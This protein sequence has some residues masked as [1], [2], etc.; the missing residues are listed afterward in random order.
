MGGR[1]SGNYYHWSKATALESTL[2]IDV[3]YMRRQGLLRPG[4][5]GTLSW[6]R[7]GEPSGS[8]RYSCWGD[9]IVFNYRHNDEP[10]EQIVYFDRTPCRFGGERLW[11]LCP[12]CRRR[13]EVLSIAGKYPACRKCY[14]LPYQS[15]CEDRLGRLI[16]RQHK[17]EAML[18]GD[19]RK[20]WRREK[21]ERL[22][23]EWEWISGAADE[24][25]VLAA[26]N[27][28]GDDDLLRLLGRTA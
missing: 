2:R 5:V 22:M 3:R 26:A 28:L 24:A 23:R 8:I 13:C 18:W 7:N 1:G 27:L 20:W 6:T 17:L 21:R 19:K 14:R 11:F 9:H 10:V 16:S 12:H 25:F 4:R 15:Q